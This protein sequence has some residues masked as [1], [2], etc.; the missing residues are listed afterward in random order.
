MSGF[1][2]QPAGTSPAG[3]GTPDL[4]DIPGGAVLRDPATGK[5]LGSRKIDSRSRDY[6]LDE[7]GRILGEADVRHLVRMALTTVRDSSVLR[8]FGLNTTGMSRI[9]G[10]FERRLLGAVTDAVRHLVTGGQI[11]VLGIS[12]YRAG[13]NGGLREGQVY[14]RFRW[15][16]L[17]TSQEHEELI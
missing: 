6:E 8:S 4:A 9:T 17:T 14:A 11:E 1:G 3:W 15:R 7:N 16:D 5:S 13:V 12:Q 2:V 10:D